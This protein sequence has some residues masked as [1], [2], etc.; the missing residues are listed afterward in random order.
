LDGYPAKTGAPYRKPGPPKRGGLHTV[1]SLLV[2]MAAFKNGR[3]ERYGFGV[4]YAPVSIPRS[5]L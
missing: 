1:P 4:C 3:N 2:Y 5:F